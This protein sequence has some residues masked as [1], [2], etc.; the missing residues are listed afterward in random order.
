MD[1]QELY[2]VVFSGQ[3]TGEYDLKTTKRRF[4][5][6][7]RRDAKYTHRVFSGKTH[8]VKSNVTEQAATDFAIKLMEIG[9]EC[10]V[11]L[12]PLYSQQA[13]FRERRK[14][15]RRL[16][17]RRD[18]RPGSVVRRRLPSRRRLD[19]IQFARGLD[20]PGRTVKK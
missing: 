2:R 9:C 11:E 12:M 7:F 5:K 1:D 3:I 17:Y 19:M 16:L 10:Y 15:V 4:A 20:F 18:P 13:G 8:A 14:G 6:A